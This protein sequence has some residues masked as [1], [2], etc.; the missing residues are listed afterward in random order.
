MFTQSK[1]NQLGPIQFGLF[2]G[3]A[4]VPEELRID[5]HS[6]DFHLTQS[7]RAP[8]LLLTPRINQSYDSNIY[9]TLTEAVTPLD[10]KTRIL[11][12]AEKLFGLNGFDATSLRDITA[13]AQVNLA[14]VNYHF[15]SKDSLIDAI[16]ERRILPINQRRF[17]MLDAAGHPPGVEQVVEAFLA[18]LLM[19]EVLPAVPLIGRVLSNPSQFVERVYKKHLQHVAER[20]SQAIREAIPELSQEDAFWRLHFMAGCMTHVLALSS[21]LPMMSGQAVDRHA[22]MRRLVNF[23]AAGLRAPV[24]ANTNAADP[25]R[26]EP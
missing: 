19:L 14:A 25:M 9:M 24:P 18:P 21:V 7:T 8:N 11:N 23:I 6:N 2:C 22:L 26:K 5:R 12:A 16:I 15:Q 4:A 17:E 20:F 10:T 3:T 1:L 13:E